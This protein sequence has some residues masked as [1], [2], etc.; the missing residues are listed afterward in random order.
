MRDFAA[1][2]WRSWESHLFWFSV[3]HTLIYENV[4]I[5][6]SKVWNMWSWGVYP[7][8]RHIY[9]CCLGENWLEILVKWWFSTQ[10]FMFLEG[11]SQVRRHIYIYII[12]FLESP[13]WLATCVVCY[14]TLSKR[15]SHMVLGASLGQTHRIFQRWPAIFWIL[16]HGTVMA[17]TTSYNWLF[18]WDYTFYKWGDLLVL[19][20]DSHGHNCTHFHSS[21]PSPDLERRLRCGSTL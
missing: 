19:I 14:S 11:M 15:R 6:D 10:Q 20:T 3:G 5:G 9:Q 4:N 12:S 1:I 7:S 13:F 8:W 2:E 16:K 21:F 18:L 17:M